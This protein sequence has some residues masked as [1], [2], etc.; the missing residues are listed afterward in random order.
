MAEN[1]SAD[2]ETDNGLEL[3]KLPELDRNQEKRGFLGIF[4][5][6]KEEKRAPIKEEIPD[7][8]ILALEKAKS[9][10]SEEVKKPNF[11]CSICAQEFK[12]HRG[13][14]AHQKQAHPN[15]IKYCLV[16]KTGDRMKNLEDLRHY[17]KYVDEDT[18]AYHT[19]GGKNDFSDWVENALGKKEMADKLRM[20]KNKAEMIRVLYGKELKIEP[21]KKEPE[22]E[23]EIEPIDDYEKYMP[24]EESSLPEISGMQ[25]KE[26]RGLFGFLGKKE[27]KPEVSKQEMLID[28][29]KAL[30]SEIGEIEAPKEPE[31]SRDDDERLSA[32]DD[33]KSELEQ[34]E[35]EIRKE[36]E[37]L[38]NDKK[39]L[40]EK[41]KEVEKKT[42]SLMSE[43]KKIEAKLKAIDEKTKK[44][45]SLGERINADEKR[46][47]AAKK[48]LA[49]EGKRI[50]AKKNEILKIK[51]S[52]KEIKEIRK[53]LPAL[54]RE[55][56][57]ISRNLSSAKEKIGKI[58]VEY[59]EKKPEIS[60]KDADLKSLDEKLKKKEDELEEKKNQ[61]MDIQ[62]KLLEEKNRIEEERFELYVKQELAVRESKPIQNE[63][64]RRTPENFGMNM[65]MPFPQREAPKHEFN[66]SSFEQGLSQ[67]KQLL[68]EGRF[69]EAK[70][71]LQRIDSANSS[72]GAS[73]YDKRNLHYKIL[74]TATDIKLAEIKARMQK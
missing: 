50:E 63:Q 56:S 5:R 61:L 26:K 40:K 25:R 51:M 58:N 17:I 36:A 53:T 74:D 16:L 67:V 12:D 48:E 9:A 20:A 8:G 24:K 72:S 52:A 73:D 32:I 45:I 22:K 4:G 35:K 38:I 18:F 31:V 27:R 66:A 1:N 21:P 55:Y 15:G 6:K 70:G 29:E 41:E 69:G 42:L 49:S 19:M 68:A 30:E 64:P 44:M 57:Q 10:S 54:K 13:L 14:K 33:I 46:V 59:E 11:S 60:K 3:P 23:Q 28:E 47:S 34:K 7:L 43:Q 37:N 71:L 62:Y 39:F 65:G 2:A